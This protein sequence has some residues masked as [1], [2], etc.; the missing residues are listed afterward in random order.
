MKSERFIYLSRFGFALL[1]LISG[2]AMIPFT[3]LSGQQLSWRQFAAVYQPIVEVNHAAGAPGSAF[4]MTGSGFPPN[5]VVT[6]FRDGSPIGT[7]MSDGAGLVEGLIETFT[8]NPEG[9][10]FISVTVN[11]RDSATTSFSLDAA[12]PL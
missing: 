12:E 8:F 3:G 4:L 10:Y 11:S 2:V 9:D 6:V 5:T 1:I 7:L